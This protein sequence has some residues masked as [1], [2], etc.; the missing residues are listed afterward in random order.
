M[1]KFQP[2]PAYKVSK[3][4]VNMLTVQWAESLESDSFM[5][6]AIC[7][8][9]SVPVCPSYPTCLLTLTDQWAKT[10][11]G[12]DAGHL[13]AEESAIGGL[14]VLLSHTAAD[15]G[16]FFVVDLPGKKIDGQ[17]IYDGSVR[18]Y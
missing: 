13:T 3:A 16:K 17:E 9:V 6:L 18:P 4:A 14:N 5:V 11:M 2:T 8:G 7:P 1:G 10:D 15:S 12:T